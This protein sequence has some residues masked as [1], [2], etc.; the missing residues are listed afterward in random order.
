[1]FDLFQNVD[2]QTDERTNIQHT[3]TCFCAT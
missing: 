3:Q 1:M 2:E